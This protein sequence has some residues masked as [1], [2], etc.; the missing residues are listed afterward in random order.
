MTDISEFE[1]IFII[2]IFFCSPRFE[3]R[4]LHLVFFNNVAKIQKVHENMFYNIKN[5]LLGLFSLERVCMS[6]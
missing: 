3:E 5:M 1:T 6:G 2:F 4:V